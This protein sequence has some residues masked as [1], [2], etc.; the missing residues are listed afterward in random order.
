MSSRAAW[1]ARPKP[2]PDLTPTHRRRAAGLKEE[3]GVF[4][5]RTPRPLGRPALTD[6]RLE[7]TAAPRVSGVAFRPQWASNRSYPKRFSLCDRRFRMLGP[8]RWWRDWLRRPLVVRE[9]GRR[10]EAYR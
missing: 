4:R 3:L 2:W 5:T 10:P 7:P 6:S 9:R 1:R 8:P